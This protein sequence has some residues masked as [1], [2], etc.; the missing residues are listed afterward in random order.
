MGSDRLIQVPGDGW[1][2]QELDFREIKSE[3]MA[4]RGADLEGRS[5]VWAGAGCE[6]HLPRMISDRLA[7]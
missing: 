4:G 2:C 7:V 5:Q 6:G 3:Q 1:D